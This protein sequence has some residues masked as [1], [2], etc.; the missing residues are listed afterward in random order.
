MNM[1]DMDEELRQALLLSLQEAGPMDTSSAPAAAAAATAAETTEA[2]KPAEPEP[3]KDVQM[4]DAPASNAEATEPA[5]AAPKADSAPASN[6]ADAAAAA[7]E[8]P[9]YDTKWFQDPAFVSELIG[10]LPGVDINDPRIQNALKEVGGE[11]EASGG[12]D[13][14]E[15]KL[16]K[17]DEEKK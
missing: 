1:E 7:G 16:E 12:A 15:A 6:S 14:S 5:A 13:S 9:A 11:G 8:G 17:K 3:A 4:A 10:S 2:S